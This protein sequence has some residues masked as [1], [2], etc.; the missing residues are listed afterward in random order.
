ISDS[1]L[2][3]WLWPPLIQAELDKLRDRFN[4]HVVRKDSSKKNPSGVAPNVAMALPEKHGGENCL[5]QVDT[6][7]LPGL[8]EVIQEGEDVLAFCTPEYSA[9][10]QVVFDSLG[11]QEITFLNIWSIFSAMLPLM[12]TH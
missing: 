1:D 10:A 7:I 11:I 5:Q 8:I 3:Q 12:S 2:I 6:S 4:N 9:R